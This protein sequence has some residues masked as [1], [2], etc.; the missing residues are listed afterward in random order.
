MGTMIT[1]AVLLGTALALLGG[2]A[3]A[4]EPVAYRGTGTYT[5]TRALLPLANGDAVMHLAHDTVATIEP[6]E[7]GF[8]YG[9]CAGI[10]HMTAAGK[11]SSQVFCTFTEIQGDGFDVRVQGDKEGGSVD[12][13]G[14]SGKWA[15]ATGTGTLKRKW[16]Q[17]DRGTYEYE[18]KIATP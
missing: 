18:F 7:T 9:D 2:A 11:Y 4:G 16:S 13:I 10:G 8:I 14:G 1:R 5:L 17:G 6:S 3:S 15:G 12:I